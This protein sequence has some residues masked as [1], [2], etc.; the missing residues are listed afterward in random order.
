M[1]RIVGPSRATTEH[2]NTLSQCNDDGCH[3]W[4]DETYS[5]T[6]NIRAERVQYR[7]AA[8]WQRS[9]QQLVTAQTAQS[10]RRGG[11]RPTIESAPCYRFCN[12][13]QVIFSLHSTIGGEAVRE[14]CLLH[15]LP[16]L[17]I[18]LF[19]TRM[20]ST[21]KSMYAVMSLHRTIDTAIRAV[22][23]NQ[24][25]HHDSFQSFLAHDAI[26]SRHEF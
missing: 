3:L 22:D 25:Q 1:L 13:S 12:H 20:N 6:S 18:F 2:C 24:I 16:D 21:L 4:I 15:S 9:Q 23:D 26:N 11:R 17:L 14:F 10:I 19:T 7:R 5:S 8:V